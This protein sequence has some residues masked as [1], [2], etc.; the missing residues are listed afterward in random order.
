MLAL[1]SLPSVNNAVGILRESG[2]LQSPNHTVRLT[3]HAI[4][5]KVGI[6]ED[7]SILINA[8]NNDDDYAVRAAAAGA[9]GTLLTRVEDVHN[10]VE[11]LLNV[12]TGDDHFIVRYAAIV[13]LGNVRDGTA[14]DTL[15]LVNRSTLELAAAIEAVGE[16]GTASR[17][18]VKE[19][20]LSRVDDKH[21]M[22]RAAVAKTLG[23]WWMEL[24]DQ[25]IQF[26]LEKMLY[27]EGVHAKSVYVQTILLQALQKVGFDD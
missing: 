17:D 25:E 16:I 21:D 10:G 13:A 19:W 4:L 26:V 9:L 24:D 18:D 7:A 3:A 23:R 12:V 27:D 5:G 2:T 1:I 11:A 6:S 14:V 8:M 22:I 15:K 20:V